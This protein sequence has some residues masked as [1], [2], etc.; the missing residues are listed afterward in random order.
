[1][2]KWVVVGS[3]LAGALPVLTGLLVHDALRGPLPP[4]EE[5]AALTWGKIWALGLV[6][7]KVWARCVLAGGLAD[8]QWRARLRRVRN[9]GIR[10]VDFR[11][12]LTQ[13]CFPLLD[14]VGQYYFWPYLLNRFVIPLVVTNQRDLRII[15]KATPCAFLLT[16]AAY[17][18]GVFVV[19]KIKALHDR[20]RD[21]E[22]LEGLELENMPPEGRN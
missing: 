22:Y 10:G 3:L 21:D 13:V 16:E 20:I 4:A 19:S 9:N 14:R 8:E 18:A 5:T 6:C 17:A 2:G 15:Q 1:S 11:Y 7:V 12:T